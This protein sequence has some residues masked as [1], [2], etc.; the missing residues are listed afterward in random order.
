MTTDQPIEHPRPPVD[1]KRLAEQMR[2]LLRHECTFPLG[3][4]NSYD[5]LGN[6]V[7]R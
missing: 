3:R 5:E 7:G 6:E 1:Y 4:A 2:E